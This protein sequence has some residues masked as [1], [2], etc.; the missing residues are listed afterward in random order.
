[1]QRQHEILNYDAMIDDVMV[2]DALDALQH[3]CA[4]PNDLGEKLGRGGFKQIYNHISK[5]GYVLGLLNISADYMDVD[6]STRW[7]EAVY[8]EKAMG[9]I[10]RGLGLK[11]PDYQI[12]QINLGK[13]VVPA[14]SMLHF[15]EMQQQG[16][17]IRDPKNCYHPDDY[18]IPPPRTSFGDSWLFG[19]RGN[20][21]NI[22]Y[23]RALYADITHDLV[24]LIANNIKLLSESFS[25]VIEN[26]AETPSVLSDTEKLVGDRKQKVRLFLFDFAQKNARLF[27]LKTFDIYNN[28]GLPDKE[29]IKIVAADLVHG[30]SETLIRGM[31]YEESQHLMLCFHE[32]IPVQFA[33]E[34]VHTITD[35]VYNKLMCEKFKS[36][37]HFFANAKIVDG[38]VVSPDK[39][40]LQQYIERIESHKTTTGNIDFQYGFYFFNRSRAVNRQANYLLAKSL[41]HK[42]EQANVQNPHGM[43]NNILEHRQAIIRAHGLDKDP[44]YVERGLNS[45]ELK[46]IIL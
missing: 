16:M 35:K 14:L 12:E 32:R 17:Y 18:K 11:T 1:M 9:D 22:A 2:F 10:L 40:S 45:A 21:Y 41:F 13:Y 26:T 31:T 29:K 34:L 25:L 3:L 24:C 36:T 44:N 42:F 28:A 8:E 6:A 46:K 19:T 39:V 30:V 5:P 27:P 37:E 43:F 33:T 7:C 38:A 4:H 15:G 23:L 20:F